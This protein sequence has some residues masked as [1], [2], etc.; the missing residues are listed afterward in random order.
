ML[1]NKFVFVII[2]IRRHHHYHHH[3]YDPSVKKTWDHGLTLILTCLAMSIISAVCLFIISTIY[4]GS[5]SICLIKPPYPLFMRLLPLNW[6][7]ATAY[8]VAFLLFT[9]INFE[10]FKMLLPDL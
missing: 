4:V 8:Y 3:K 5:E 2:I 9:L 10:E 1:F 6:T 7:T